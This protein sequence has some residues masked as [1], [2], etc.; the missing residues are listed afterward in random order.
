MKST[1]AKGTHAAEPGLATVEHQESEGRAKIVEHIYNLATVT[2]ARRNR[3][4]CSPS[5]ALPQQDIIDACPCRSR[6]LRRAHLVLLAR[7]YGNGGRQQLV[8]MTLF[9]D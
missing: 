9:S 1:S 2:A 8:S 4:A 5:T 7:P 6:K 3:L